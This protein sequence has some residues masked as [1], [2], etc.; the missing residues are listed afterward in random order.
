MV[1]KTKVSEVRLTE[2]LFFHSLLVV[3]FEL[4]T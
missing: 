4:V 2:F 3:G 1:V